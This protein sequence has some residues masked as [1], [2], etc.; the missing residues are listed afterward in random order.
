MSI[1]SMANLESIESI[2]SASYE[3]YPAMMQA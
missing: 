3:P 1:P 2:F